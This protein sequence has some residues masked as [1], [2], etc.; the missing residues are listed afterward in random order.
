MALNACPYCDHGNP[1]EA[2]FCNACG[3]A[4]HLAPCPRCGA[5][6]EITA[7]TCYQCNAKLP[8]RKT[9]APDA[10]PT[11]EAALGPLSRWRRRAIAGTTALAA[12]AVL[13]YYG[14]HQRPL[15]E[16]PQPP[17]ASSQASDSGSSASAGVIRQE[18]APADA[19]PIKAEEGDKPASPAATPPEPPLAGA[20]P[21]ATT[22]PRAGRDPVVSRD[23]K[24]AAASIA[25]TKAINEGRVSQRRP[26][27]PQPCT[28]AVAA[29][30]LC[31]LQPVQKKEAETAAAGEPATAPSVAADPGTA[32]RAG[33]ASAG[34]MHGG[35]RGPWAV[36]A[37]T[38]TEEGIA[39]PDHSSVR[40]SA[41]SWQPRFA[42]T[43]G[44]PSRRP[45]TRS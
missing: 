15:D 42:F 16:A 45:N 11:A 3:G 37:S 28:E 36:H 26:S 7:T 44:P 39:C 30:G 8:G 19:A 1:A 13:G 33:A 18:S 6:S 41:R 31:T 43:A 12:I 35:G 34:G 10:V 25:R 9:D 38:H 14:Y 4:L 20:A 2:K 22:P 17:A 27:R 40:C 5:V 32:R 24:A 29:L 23:M 21:A